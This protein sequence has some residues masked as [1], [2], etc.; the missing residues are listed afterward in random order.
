MEGGS[1]HVDQRPY[2]AHTDSVEDIQWSPNEQNVRLNCVTYRNQLRSGS[3]FRCIHVKP[4]AAN[5]YHS[6]QLKAVYDVICQKRG[7]ALRHGL[8]GPGN[9]RSL[10]L[11]IKHEARVFELSS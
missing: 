11:V 6:C 9:R 3:A 2:S 10:E 1:W 7:G 4:K 8:Q 5:S